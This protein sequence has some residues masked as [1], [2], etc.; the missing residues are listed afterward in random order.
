MGLTTVKM[1]VRGNETSAAFVDLDFLVDSGAL[2]SVIPAGEWER[3]GIIP[4][5]H[6]PVSLA[7][8]TVLDRRIGTAS[9]TYGSVER[10]C[11]VLL[12]EPGDEPLLGAT[13]LEN[14]GYILDPLKRRIVSARIR[15]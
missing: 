6:V 2:F 14:L 5:E 3:I 12:G 15:M 1:R 10:P 8:G 11:T 9:L 13:A 7:D 4:K